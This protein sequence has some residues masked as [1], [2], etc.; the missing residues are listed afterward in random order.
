MTKD[1]SQKL[2][3]LVLGLAI[4]VTLA[5]L[6]LQ[7]YGLNKSM[8]IDSSTLYNVAVSDD[9][10]VGGRSI[11]SLNYD[12]NAIEMTC[13]INT[14]YAWPYCQLAVEFADAPDG[15]DLSG[16]DTIELDVSI[17]GPGKPSLRVYLRNFNPAYANPSRSTTLKV[18]E[19]EYDTQVYDGFLT[20]PLSTFSV[21]A[22]WRINNNVDISYGQP[23]FDN[24][25]LMELSTG[26]IVENGRYTISM[27]S[28]K[29]TGKLVSQATIMAY[30]LCMWVLLALVFII[31][32]YWL[33]IRRQ[34]RRKERHKI[35]QEIE[36]ALGADTAE[37]K[38]DPVTGLGTRKY[39][40]SRIIDIMRDSEETPATAILVEID[41]HCDYYHQDASVQE[42][43]LAD[44]AR[45]VKRNTR[46]KDI[47]IR[48]HAT[49]LLIIC[50]A[51]TTAQTIQL[52]EKIRQLSE[53]ANWRDGLRLTLSMGVVQ[54]NNT[55]LAVFSDTLTQALHRARNEGGNRT[56]ALLMKPGQQEPKLV[57]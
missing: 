46:E 7:R 50:P 18:N 14:S 42:S 57:N 44:L 16:Y 56:V 33:D 11:A 23:E 31:A 20:L 34:M 3:L 12:E 49:Q 41:H 19:V 47:T 25:T 15:I 26:S 17:T 21:P 54:H 35:L 27:R 30:L 51:T 38:F 4:F 1:T 29:F 24:V 45:L 37:P 22:W 43:L 55:S 39:L 28:V 2:T 48:W 6:L 52:A 40:R 32:Q 9:R 36:A 5:A 10:P 8:T 53:E 13:D